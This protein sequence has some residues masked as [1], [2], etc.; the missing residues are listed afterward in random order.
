LK[1]SKKKQGEIEVEKQRGK[2]DTRASFNLFVGSSRK[3]IIFIVI[4]ASLA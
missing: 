4:S 3:T 1:A 2:K